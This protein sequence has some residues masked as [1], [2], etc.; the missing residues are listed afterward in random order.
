MP[1]LESFHLTVF[2]KSSHLSVLTKSIGKTHPQ[3]KLKRLRELRISIFG[4]LVHLINYLKEILML[5]F[6]L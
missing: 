5:K 6:S 3:I 1:R 4:Q 2:R